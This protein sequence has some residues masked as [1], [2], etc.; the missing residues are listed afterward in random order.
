MYIQIRDLAF[1][2]ND[3]RIQF[4]MIQFS[5]KYSNQRNVRQKR[6]EQT[7]TQN[8]T[9]FGLKMPTSPGLSTSNN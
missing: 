9:E 6:K 1:K 5:Q 2:Y 7:R 3:S 4:N 8:V